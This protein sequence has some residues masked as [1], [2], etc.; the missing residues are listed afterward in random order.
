MDEYQQARYNRYHCYRYS[1]IFDYE[2]A[3]FF[4]NVHGIESIAIVFGSE[5]PCQLRLCS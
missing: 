1:S 3:F 5:H 2:S 4:D